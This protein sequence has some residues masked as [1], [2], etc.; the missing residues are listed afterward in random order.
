MSRLRRIATHDRIFFVTTNVLRP[1]LPLSEA[2]RDTVLHVVASQHARGA[3][4]L[5]GYVVMPD[6]LHL[7]LRPH[8]A[9]LSEGI[10]AIKSITAVRVMRHRD[11]RGP[12]WQPRYFDNIV[13]HVGELWKKLEYI[14][15][16]PLAAEL[17]ARADEWR[18]SSF[19]AYL[20]TGAAPIPIDKFDL[21]VDEHA[22]LWPAL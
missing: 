21:P 20:P 13:R 22:L 11:D 12:L 1:R 10:R 9:D 18:W 2:E 7:L 15:N 17:V 4:W 6:H 5:Y 16:N 14:H 19:R 3:F 8:N